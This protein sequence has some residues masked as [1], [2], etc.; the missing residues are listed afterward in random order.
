VCPFPGRRCIYG[1]E[2]RS[3]GTLRGEIA[4]TCTT[5]LRRRMGKRLASF[6]NSRR[7]RGGTNCRQFC[8]SHLDGRLES[9]GRLSAILTSYMLLP[10][11]CRMSALMTRLVFGAISVRILCLCHFSGQCPIADDIDMPFAQACPLHMLR[12]PRLRDGSSTHSVTYQHDG[13]LALRHLFRNSAVSS[14]G[15]RESE[16]WQ[17]QIAK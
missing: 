8:Q 10:S 15:A 14:A 1:S 4:A 2:M 12:V 5:N 16:V 7:R 9:A 13:K 6:Q 11:L 17:L 3:N